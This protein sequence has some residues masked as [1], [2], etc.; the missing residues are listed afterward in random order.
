MAPLKGIATQDMRERSRI[1]RFLWMA[2][3][4][5]ACLVLL[6]FA[7]SAGLVSGF[8]T[9]SIVLSA[10]AVNAVFF[11]LLRRGRSE[12]FRDPDLVWPQTLC[13]IAV[14]A[15]ALYHFDY[16]RSLVLMVSFAIFTIGIF[17]FTPREFLVTAGLIFGAYA[18]VSGLLVWLKP[19]TVDVDRKSVV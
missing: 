5:G 7:F 18:C 10:V 16:D 19:A 6:V 1:R 17:R 4:Y 14:S 15:V 2:G 13:A 12:R 9:V 3:A 8:G 11:V